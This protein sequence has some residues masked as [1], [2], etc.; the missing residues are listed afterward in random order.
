M[1]CQQGRH[2]EQRQR[3]AD[4]RGV[5]DE[6]PKTRLEGQATDVVTMNS[7]FRPGSTEVTNCT[8]AP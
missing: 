5:P 1:L 7:S 3:L 2:P 4:R 6:V 8:K